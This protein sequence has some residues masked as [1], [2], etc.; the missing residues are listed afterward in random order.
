MTLVNK[1]HRKESFESMVRRFKKTCERSDIINEVKR[2]ESYEK[3]SSVKKRSREL[4]VN[5]ERKRQEDQK[6]KKT[7]V[8]R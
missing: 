7:F 2:R 5:K 4:A 3:P 6:P 1:K 8:S